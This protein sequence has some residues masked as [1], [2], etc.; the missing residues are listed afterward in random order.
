VHDLKAG[1]VSPL[2]LI[3]FIRSV[4]R[5]RIGPQ[6]QR[7]MTMPPRGQPARGLIISALMSAES[8]AVLRKTLGAVAGFN[9]P[10]VRD[11]KLGREAPERD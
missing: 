8:L 3:F 6:A 10:I 5:P 11:F 7:A 2:R 9:L 4:I 1:N